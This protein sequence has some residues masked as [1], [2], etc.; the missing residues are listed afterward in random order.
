MPSSMI[1][2]GLVLLWLIVLVPT[3]ARHR[4]EVA[5]PSVAALSGRVLARPQRRGTVEVETMQAD[6]ELS[7][8][9]GLVPETAVHVPAAREAPH[10]EPVDD[11]G[12]ESPVPRYRPGRGGFDPEAAR[13]AARARY[14]VRQRVVLGLLV[15]AVAS[16]V[17]AA[18]VLRPAWWVHGG[19]DLALVGYLVYLRRQVRLE[20]AIRERRAAR[21]AGARHGCA[22]EDEQVG[23]DGDGAGHD[24]RGGYGWAAGDDAGTGG[25]PGPDDEWADDA[26]Y[27][28]DDD[29]GYDGAGA[30]FE[31]DPDV[32]GEVGEALGQAGGP[33]VEQP[34]RVAG[35]G[36]PV[37]PLRAA[38][39]DEP[40]LP[41]LQPTPLPPLPAGTALVEA[42]DADLALGDL[43]LPHR[44]A[45]GE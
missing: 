14:V 25:D 34:M 16:A 2:I 40:A 19:V 41:R 3:V 9:A 5:R 22:G 12:W 31:D 42:D 37:G 7:G 29:T 1:F 44:R 38:A 45:V 6:I 33:G 39:V 28:D 30:G 11:R 15:A 32:D 20:E 43:D 13:L 4:Q 26:G 35:T 10:D 27:D 24:E 8:G 23:D 18:L 17:V 36:E 21:L